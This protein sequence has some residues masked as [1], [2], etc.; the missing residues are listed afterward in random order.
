MHQR[1]DS[2]A[3]TQ[4]KHINFNNTNK[5]SDFVRSYSFENN[6]DSTIKIRNETLQNYVPNKLHDKENIKNNSEIEKSSKQNKPLP[7]ES[8]LIQK[9]SRILEKRE[10]NKSKTNFTPR[11]HEESSGNAYVNMKHSKNEI[12]NRINNKYGQRME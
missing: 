3:S 4:Y 2:K 5:F 8:V 9:V 10:M 12:I 6:G 1:E 7:N 11:V